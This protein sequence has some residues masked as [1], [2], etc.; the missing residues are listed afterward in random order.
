MYNITINSETVSECDAV[1][2][3]ILVTAKQLCPVE[4]GFG[5]LIRLSGNHH[6]KVQ[7]KQKNHLISD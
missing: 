4:G 3:S 7:N 6:C 5:D 1:S 2:M